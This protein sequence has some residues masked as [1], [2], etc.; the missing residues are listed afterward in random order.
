MN[1]TAHGIVCGLLLVAPACA[2]EA[3]RPVE[4]STT[5]SLADGYETLNIS[6][7]EGNESGWF[8]YSD[9]TP[10]GVPVPADPSNVPVSKLDPPRCGSSWAIKLEAYGN[11]YWGAGFGDWTHN[12]F[13]SRAQGPGYQGISFWARAG[14]GTDKTFL[15]S[16]DD[17]RTIK[18]PRVAPDGGALPAANEGDQ[19]LDGDGFLGPGDIASG[20]YCR[21]PPPQYIGDPTCYYGGTQAPDAVTR[22]PEPGE[23]GNTFH[24]YVTITEDWQLYLI[25]WTRLVQ[26][27]CPNRLADGID[28]NDIRKLDIRLVQGS[29]YEIWLDDISFYRLR[30]I[31]DAGS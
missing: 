21:L 14:A 4:I 24:T 30:G 17:G 1:R 28:P 5:C 23:C 9:H 31:A 25:P 11:N 7:F 27:P 15:L 3:R 18:A 16:I 12:S 19:D 26:W 20:T 29:H 22:V 10:G 8:F 6:D 2:E 13:S